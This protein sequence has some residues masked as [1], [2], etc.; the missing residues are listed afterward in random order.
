MLN[1][2]EKNLISR[3][4]SLSSLVLA[5]DDVVKIHLGAHIDGFAAVS[6]ETIVV[7]ATA[8][9]PVTG[10]RADAL[11]AAWHAAEVSMRLIKAGGKN[12]AITDAVAKT[13]AAFDC[14][15]VEGASM[16]LFTCLGFL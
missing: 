8:E 5:K 6:A 3:S 16:R 4:D 15:A 14:K 9:N 2:W 13:A 11:Q 12:W 10:R 1:C 7:G